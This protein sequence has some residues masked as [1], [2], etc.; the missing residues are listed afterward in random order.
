VAVLF[1]GPYTAA[2]WT[3]VVAVGLLMPLFAELFE[4][5]QHDYT[6]LLLAAVPVPGRRRALSA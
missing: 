3:M 4:R 5:P 1:G 2:F 6:K